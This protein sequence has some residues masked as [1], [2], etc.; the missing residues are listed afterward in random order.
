MKK[1]KLCTWSWSKRRNSEVWQSVEHRLK[2]GQW[3]QKWVKDTK[4]ATKVAKEL[5]SKK[6]QRVAFNNLKG[7]MLNPF[8]QKSTVPEFQYLKYKKGS[9]K[10]KLPYDM[11]HAYYKNDMI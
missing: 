1:I 8:I 3:D 4:V 10:K 5:K 2:R 7:F 11:M 6:E 9:P